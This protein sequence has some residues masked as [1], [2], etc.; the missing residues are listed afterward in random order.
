M[1][2]PKPK[3]ALI[4]LA[5]G[6]AIITIGTP[7]LAFSIGDTFAEFVATQQ[8]EVFG[9]PTSKIAGYIKNGKMNLNTIF[10]DVSKQAY[11]FIKGS[12]DTGLIKTA[13]EQMADLNQ[14]KNEISHQENTESTANNAK[15]FK[16]NA[17]RVQQTVSENETE[18]DSSVE[19]TDKTNKLAAANVTTTQQLTKATLDLAVS[20]QNQNSIEI[21][22]GQRERTERL[23]S[24]IDSGF[25]QN[26]V[27]RLQVVAHRRFYK[28]KSGE[29]VD[30]KADASTRVFNGK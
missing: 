5:T 8:G 23:K 13:G 22:K 20:Q 11:D 28:D 2:L 27:E 16:D 10:T 7:A 1:K 14:D 26:E 24:Q 25:A 15:F 12:G 19:A 21:E 29:M 18:S 9:V 6:A 3:K 4:M 30:S 17:S